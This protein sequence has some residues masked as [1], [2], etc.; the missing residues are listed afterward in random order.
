MTN[1]FLPAQPAAPA[2][3]QNPYAAPAAPANPYAPAA[4]AAPG[5][6]YAP[7]AQPQYTQQPVQYPG[8]NQSAPVPPG[9]NGL[10]AQPGQFTTPPPP[11][12]SGGNLPKISDLQGR[13]L[14][15]MPES[16]QH[17]VASKFTNR[18]GSPQFQDRITATVVVLDG[19]PLQWGGMQP[20][21]ARQQGDVPYVIKG[22][23]IQQSKLIEQL[24]EPLRMRLDG[25]P[26]LALGRL[27]K[28]G[29]AASDPYVLATPSAEDVAQ[30]DRY[31]TQ[32]NPFAL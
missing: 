25:Q 2:Q 24:G 13:L 31:V 17:G 27:W 3:Q 14:I 19:G 9:G 20:G 7:A 28:T 5:N 8:Q 16:M 26:G 30:Y 1:P 6:P 23:W 15:V 21:S 18:D 10:V 12:P 32:V 11:S 29:T 22:L 4:P